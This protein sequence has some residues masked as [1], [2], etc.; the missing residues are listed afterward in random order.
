MKNLGTFLDMEGGFHNTAYDSIKCVSEVVRFRAAKQDYAS[1]DTYT[2]E[3]V[4]TK[5][6]PQGGVLLPLLWRLVVK[7]TRG[8][9]PM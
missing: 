2:K 5:G 4:T 6:C 1:I 9:Y 7:D 8:L 3:T